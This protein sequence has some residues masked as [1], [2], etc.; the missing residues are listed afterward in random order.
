MHSVTDTHMHPGH[1]HPGW[2]SAF[3]LFPEED[4][5]NLSWRCPG[6]RP[7]ASV[8]GNYLAF[9]AVSLGSGISLHSQML[10]AR[11][12]SMAGQAMGLLRSLQSDLVGDDF[13]WR[14]E[15]L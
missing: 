11:E 1:T 5:G 2:P 3:G 4:L 9:A 15:D 6:A 13:P 14:T 12:T 7:R 10:H 8:P